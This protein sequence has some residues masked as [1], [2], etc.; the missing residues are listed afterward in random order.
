MADRH[1][2]G[3]GWLHAV[4]DA[5]GAELVVLDSRGPNARPLLW[6]GSNPWKRHSPVLFPIVGRLPDDRMALGDTE[7]RLPQHGFARDRVFEWVSRSTDGCVLELIDDAESRRIFPCAFRLQL[8]YRI[9][10][11]KLELRYVLRNPDTTADLHAAVGAHPAFLWPQEP[12]ALR[13]AHRLVFS[14]EEEKTIWR[15]SD[16]LLRA[17]PEPSPL[18]GRELPLSDSLFVDDALIFRPV[19]SHGVQFLGPRGAGLEMSWRGFPEL[20]VWTKPGAGF[21]CIEPWHGYAT[22]TG[23]HGDFAVKP[24][25]LHIG[26]QQSWEAAW[27]VRAIG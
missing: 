16:G 7:V 5:A 25:N 14:D 22:P 23:F 18:V 2:F 26:P 6:D 20:G 4:V 21:L 17:Q 27:T 24:G 3:D 12:G 13:E 11:G 9:A 15:V 8:H 1:E 19:R 10:A